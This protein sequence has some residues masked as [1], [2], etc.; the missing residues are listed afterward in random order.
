MKITLTQQELEHAISCYLKANAAVEI[1]EMTFSQKRT[2]IET[3]VET[4]IKEVLTPNEVVSGEELPTL[5]PTIQEDFES[6]SEE[7]LY[8]SDLTEEFTPN[9]EELIDEVSEE[10]EPT[11][12]EDEKAECVQSDET[13]IPDKGTEQEGTVQPLVFESTVSTDK[14]EEMPVQ[15]TLSIADILGTS[16]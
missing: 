6:T 2:G 7:I 11:E 14:V 9:P 16:P 3:I 13:S 10:T 4:S 12:V 1:G 15:D 8:E 5:E